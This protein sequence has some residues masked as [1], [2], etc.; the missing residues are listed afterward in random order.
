[1]NS[2]CV[3]PSL[4]APC[5]TLRLQTP[6]SPGSCTASLVC[7]EGLGGKGSDI[8]GSVL[9]FKKGQWAVNFV[10]IKWFH[11][12]HFLERWHGWKETSDWHFLTAFLSGRALLSCE[13]PASVWTS[14]S[15]VVCLSSM[16]APNPFVLLVYHPVSTWGLFCFNLT[17]S[18]I[19]IFL[20]LIS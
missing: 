19:S 14:P 7:S 4:S 18:G 5:H 20:F 17:C 2:W 10:F 11:F 3:C 1:M 6:G 16:A 12:D 13:K 8:Q 15:P 9:S